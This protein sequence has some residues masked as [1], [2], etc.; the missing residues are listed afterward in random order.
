MKKKIFISVAVLIL[1]VG[2]ALIALIVKA[3]DVLALYKPK[4]EETLS[5][6]LGAKVSLGE[7][8]VSLF[9]ALAVNVDA[10]K[11][12]NE[13]GE[14]V[15]LSLG[16][17]RA[18]A[19]LLPLLSKRLE[20][21]AI[22]LVRPALTVEKSAA[23]VVIPGL[24]L[25]SQ[26]KPSTHTSAPAG[27][28]GGTKKDSPAT[29]S[30]SGL[31][32]QIEEI[33]I[34]DG[35]LL[36]NDKTTGRTTSVNAIQLSSEVELAGALTT[37]PKT[38]L[39]FIVKDTPPVALSATSISFNKESSQLSL[40]KV[41]VDTEAGS[42]DAHGQINSKDASG[43][44]DISSKGLGLKK[45]ATLASPFAPNLSALG[46]G[47]DLSFKVSVK[48]PTSPLPHVTGSFTLAGVT[49]LSAPGVAVNDIAGTVALAGAATDLNLKSD[50]LKLTYQQTPLTVSFNTQ[51]KPEALTLSALTVKGF[52]GSTDVSANLSQ[53]GAKPY[54]ANI[55]AAALSL[56]AL[57]RTFKPDLQKHATGTITSLKV[58]PK[59]QLTGDIPGSIQA[60][61]N[62]RITNAV[63]KG[64]NLPNVIL[65][66]VDSIPFLEGALRQFVP[67]EFEPYLTTAD[68]NIREFTATFTVQGRSLAISSL[69][70]SSDIFSLDGNGTVGADGAV[71]MNTTFYFT[72]D[73]SQALTQRNKNMKN[74]LAPDGRL[75][76]PLSI[77][78]KAPALVAYPDVAKIIQTGAAKA[79]QDKAVSA[80]EKALDKGG[81]NG[82]LGK[83]LG[84]F[85][86]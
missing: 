36:F 74:I 22:E 60:P 68:T 34:R 46:L 24:S 50:A 32:I 30:D 11:L 13:K 44:L 21:S 54:S 86:F 9:P 14:R 83:A 45:L 58:Q 81:K 20:L 61:G 10:V 19:A 17:L 78:G 59:G 16:S 76:I 31:A 79:L 3:N 85:G 2:G 65:T 63:L 7:L 64:T 12:T 73:F 52:G 26:S 1:L 77:R 67:R 42:I 55:S 62:I 80:L 43:T 23:G 56:E 33:S 27:V 39:R 4:I 29:P 6:A 5:S 15:P 25:P 66:K 18:E 8:S 51:L 75:I 41:T 72:K 82:G 71:S 37:L 40:G 49:V 84:K 48:N 28:Q 47:G 35:E 53:I 70:L 69:A 57:L 38:S